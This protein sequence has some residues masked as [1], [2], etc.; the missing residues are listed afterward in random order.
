[1]ILHSSL[2]E[3]N[4]IQRPV[5]PLYCAANKRTFAYCSPAAKPFSFVPIAANV[6]LVVVEQIHSIFVKNDG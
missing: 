4:D 2:K 6:C 1:M 3:G 5:K